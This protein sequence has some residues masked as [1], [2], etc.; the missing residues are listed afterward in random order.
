M[1]PAT[2]LCV[3]LKPVLRTEVPLRLD[4]A[5]AGVRAVEAQAV[6]NPADLAAVEQAL[7]LREGVGAGT[8]VLA[9]TVGPPAADAVLREALALGCDAVLRVWHAAWPPHA[10]A[11]DGTARA[12][13]SAAEAAAAVLHDR[14]PALVLT[15]E[16][17]AD[18]GHACFGA[19]LAHALA[20]D[21][22]H[23]VT[24]VAPAAQGGWEVVVRLERGYGQALAL[25]TP[26]VV[27][28]SA[29]GPRPA[30]AP[31]P[32]WI[33]AQQT[34]VPVEAVGLAPAAAAETTL[35]IPVPRV[36]RYAVPPATLPAEARIQAMVAM[37]A[38]SG[39]TLLD[40]RGSAT[41]RDAAVDAAVALL[42]ERGYR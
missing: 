28:V 15:G 39:G 20:A 36:K 3:C 11:L 16:R 23:R 8:G 24:R 14:T 22:A 9:L 17:S 35:R 33:S 41:D 40:A 6:T 5:G 34:P 2:L 21:F 32:A 18:A 26:A 13:R 29:Q 19:F 12:T 38:G 25:G 31:L 30:E 27:T 4:P 37:E 1:R 7:A 42:R 10:G